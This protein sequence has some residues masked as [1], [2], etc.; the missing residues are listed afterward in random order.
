MNA[1]KQRRPVL[2]AHFSSSSVFIYQKAPKCSARLKEHNSFGF[3]ILQWQEK[4]YLIRFRYKRTYSSNMEWSAICRV[5]LQ[6]GQLYRLFTEDGA[7]T[8]M[9]L[10]FKQCSSILEVSFVNMYFI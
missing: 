9:S 5:C 3:Y 8:A 10:K 4:L 6:E 2:L 7:D 1:N